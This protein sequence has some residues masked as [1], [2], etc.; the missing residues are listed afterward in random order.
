MP[1]SLEAA[2]SR[3]G[4]LTRSP[5]RVPPP[6]RCKQTNGT[7]RCHSR[8][9]CMRRLGFFHRDHSSLK[10]KDSAPSYLFIEC[11]SG[12]TNSKS[13]KQWTVVAVRQ[14]Q[15]HSARA[16]RKRALWALSAREPCEQCFSRLVRSVL[17]QRKLFL[18]SP[19]SLPPSFTS[20]SPSRVPWLGPRPTA[21]LTSAMPPP[22]L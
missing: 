16:W 3:R 15:P 1:S 9:S 13:K 11:V 10:W 12:S 22:L 2:F 20:P 17:E 19:S 8:F 6:P 7:M 21:I 14:L 4:L 5:Q 18:Y